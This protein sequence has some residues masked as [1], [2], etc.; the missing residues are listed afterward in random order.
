MNI[1]AIFSL[2]EVNAS[3]SVSYI[4]KLPSIHLSDSQIVSFLVCPFSQS[5][6]KYVPQKTAISIKQLFPS[7]MSQGKNCQTS[8]WNLGANFT[9]INQSLL[10]QII[11]WESYDY[12][13]GE[14]FVEWETGKEPPKLFPR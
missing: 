10:F 2:S 4:E 13:M 14:S 3:K 5:F 9:I 7:L 6:K 8:W 11:H 12:K 1:L